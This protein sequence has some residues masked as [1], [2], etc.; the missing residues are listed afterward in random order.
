MREKTGSI[1]PNN[2]FILIVCAF[3]AG[4]LGLN[5]FYYIGAK[6]VLRRKFGSLLFSIYGVFFVVAIVFALVFR[7]D[8]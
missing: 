6:F 7:T 2:K 3:V 5:T 4:I 8:E 1:H